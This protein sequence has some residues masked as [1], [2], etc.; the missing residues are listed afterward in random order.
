[1]PANLTPDYYKAEQWYR[2][3][4]TNEEKII[5]LEQMLAV[6][7]KH[8]GTDHLKA[9]LRRK[10]SALKEAPVGKAK[11]KHVDIFHVQ[12]NGVGQIVLIGTPNCGKSSIVAALT[13]AKVHIAEF[14]FATAMPVPGMMMFEDVQI[15]LVDMPPITAD[16]IAPGQ[17]GTYR[18][19][20]LIA[21]V[22]DL[23]ADVTEQMRICLDFLESKNLLIDEQT[24]AADGLGNVLGKKALCICTKCDIAKPGSLEAL[25]QAC[26]YQFEFVEISTETA[27]G[28]DKLPAL[29]FHLLGIIRI[30]AKPPGKKP[31]MADPFT[32]PVGSNVSDLAT[33]IHRELADKLKFAKIWG[34]DVYQGQNVQKNHILS[35]KDIIEL[36][37]A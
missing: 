7:P 4:T 19:C 30:Y 6:M 2:E 21:I 17:V 28:L 23:S 24:P 14:P 32:L 26:K 35:D 3:A 33:A 12:R 15:Q 5:A 9:D 20:D 25:K 27:K 37:F 11:G 1:M 8:K 16:H 22:I 10:L 29:L 18:N 31:D 34:T 13:N 36:H